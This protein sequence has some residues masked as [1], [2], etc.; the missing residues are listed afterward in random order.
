MATPL[1]S[2]GPSSRRSAIVR[3]SGA[4]GVSN[5]KKS[6]RYKL[7]GAVM[8]PSVPNVGQ[9]PGG[10]PPPIDP[11]RLWE[12]FG[13]PL[14][15]FLARRVPPGV[16]ADD[17][18]QEVFLRV[19]R[20]LASLRSTER[21]EAWLYQIAR[22]ALRDSLRARLRRDGRTDALEIDVPA[23]PD[24]AAD[25]AAEAELAPCLTAMIARLGEP[26]RTAITLTSLQG[27]TQ[28][29]AARQVGMSISGMKSRV[30]RGRDQLRQ[31]LVTCCAI[32]VDVRGGV[33]DFH[34]REPGA[35]R[36]AAAVTAAGTCRP[37]P[38]AP[39]PAPDRGASTE[40]GGRLQK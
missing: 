14:R 1:V 23:E 31:M 38:C 4:S 33:S 13:P 20:S 8:S 21:P 24:A 22:N 7:L 40:A 34:M 36:A 5:N 2:L 17:L 18:V 10:Q 11:G 19:I 37:G 25:R 32:A 28:A 3:P 27:V 39:A 35:C 30:Q 16:D 15:G 26:Y 29:D 12:E 6:R 9:E